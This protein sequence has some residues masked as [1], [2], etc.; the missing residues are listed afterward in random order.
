MNIKHIFN[1]VVSTEI[2]QLSLGRKVFL[3]RS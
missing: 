1:Q 3:G 2:L